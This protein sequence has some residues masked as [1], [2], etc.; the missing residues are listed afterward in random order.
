MS[1]R[2][3]I[4]DG[5]ISQCSTCYQEDVNTGPVQRPGSQIE[6]SFLSGKQTCLTM[7]YALRSIGI[8][9]LRPEE[10]P[11]SDCSKEQRIQTP[12]G[13]VGTCTRAVACAFASKPQP[14]TGQKPII[15]PSFHSH[16]ASSPS[17]SVSVGSPFTLSHL[18][19]ESTTRQHT[20]L[21]AAIVVQQLHGV[22]DGDE[23][24]G[25]LLRCVEKCMVGLVVR[26][27]GVGEL[28]GHFTR[29]LLFH[30]DKS[31]PCGR[32]GY[33]EPSLLAFV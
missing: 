31:G 33:P 22:V 12:R 32:S 21:A 28:S 18:D 27:L 6:T 14:R 24:H 13:A 30:L 10:E 4:R 17:V 1:I 25:S 11:T 15:R 19:C 5:S 26:F 16:N 3:E 8:S 20:S 7:V 29:R 2:E 9:A 23:F